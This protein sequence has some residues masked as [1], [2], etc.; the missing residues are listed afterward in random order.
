MGFGSLVGADYSI[1]I[2]II[3]LQILRLAVYSTG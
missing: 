2:V 1:P 3:I